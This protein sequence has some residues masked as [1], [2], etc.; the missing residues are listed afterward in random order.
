MNV[1]QQQIP[2]FRQILPMIAKRTK[3]DEINA[4]LKRSYLWPYIIILELKTNMRVL[5]TGQDNINVA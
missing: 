3:A 4:S 2:D 1:S 5:C